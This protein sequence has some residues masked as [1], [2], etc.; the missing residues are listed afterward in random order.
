MHIDH[1]ICGEMTIVDDSCSLVIARG[2]SYMVKG[3]VETYFDKNNLIKN[4][5]LKNGDVVQLV[6]RQERWSDERTRIWVL[7]K[8]A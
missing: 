1:K 3:P 6:D 2:W 8:E 7:V 5:C 4:R